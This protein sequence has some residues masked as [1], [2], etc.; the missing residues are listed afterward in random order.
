MPICP[1]TGLS[2][3]HHEL[4]RRHYERFGLPVPDIHP[5]ARRIQ[6]LAHAN[7]WDLYW[8]TDTRTGKKI[9]SC[10]DPAE[11]P[12]IYDRSYWMSDDFDA[13]QYGQA[14]DFSRS[15]FDQYF[16]MVSSIPKSNLVV[17]SGENIDYCNNASN[18]KNCYLS[19][20]MLGS[21][22]LMY[23]ARVFECRDSI[24]LY[25]CRKCEMSYA[26]ADCFGCY[27][28]RW[29]EFSTHCTD[30]AFLSNCRDCIDCYQCANISHKQYCIQNV[31]VTQQ[32]YEKH[33][34]AID[35]GSW[36]VLQNEG[37]EWRAFLESQPLQAQHN[38]N[39]EDSTGVLMKNCRAC[40]NCSLLTNAEQCYESWGNIETENC[41]SSGEDAQY[42]TSTLGIVSCQRTACSLWLEHSYDIFYSQYIMQSH[43]CF[44]CYG[45]RK[46]SHGIFNRQYPL[47]EYE[48]L[49]KK[50]IAHMKETGEWGTY[51]PPRFAAYPYEK[52]LAK[53]ITSTE[54]DDNAEMMKRFGFR[55]E[56][57]N[58]A[59]ACPGGYQASELP[60]HCDDADE[61]L[62]KLTF[63]CSESGRPYNI[64][65][66]ELAF[67]KKHRVPV[68]RISWRT[69][70]EHHYPTF[71]PS[72]HATK[73]AEC[74]KGMF[75]YLRPD[76]TTRRLLCDSC[77]NEGRG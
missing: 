70:I 65:K 42:N 14:F 71:Y 10:Y 72:P 30:S 54:F 46:T 17:L 33:M 34:R 48:E 2:F 64:T 43:D 50:I 6:K 15:F 56:K 61:A 51:F 66:Q 39:C 28:L 62:T 31:Q 52:T 32:E 60:D 67:Y 53:I 45:V 47:A 4:E 77:F 35:F 25:N 20:N 73:C 7:A 75:S 41:D 23:C 16:E 40:I 1:I 63:L 76:K 49:K 37:S 55:F 18:S 58:D 9:L 11:H 24:N 8:T 74:S 3:E 13:K 59:N 36:R 19:F 57:R 29:S 69:A 68:P 38:T 21:E 5:I 26:C 44:G 22:N 12:I 27:N